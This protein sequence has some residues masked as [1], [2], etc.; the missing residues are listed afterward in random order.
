M[1]TLS[2]L[3]PASASAD[4][5]ETLLRTERTYA[6]IH[7]DR[8]GRN[9]GRVRRLIPPGC[10][11]M[12]V[13]KADAYGHGLAVCARFMEPFTDAFAVA[14]L[15]EALTVRRSGVKKTVLLLGILKQQ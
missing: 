6:E 10:K 7:L 4:G 2:S 15:E 9:L 8:L 3:S 1:G 5:L 14:T 12:S 13:L 11:V